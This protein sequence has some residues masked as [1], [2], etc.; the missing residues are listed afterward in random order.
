M[1]SAPLPNDGVG[2]EGSKGG[3]AV[4]EFRKKLRSPSL[5]QLLFISLGFILRTVGNDAQRT[6]GVSACIVL[7][8]R[9]SS[10]EHSSETN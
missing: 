10:S 3:A 5:F 4:F 7:H 9:S 8:R 6:L 1:F 2:V